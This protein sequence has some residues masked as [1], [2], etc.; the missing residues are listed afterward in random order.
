MRF[1]AYFDGCCLDSPRVQVD[2]FDSTPR[3]MRPMTRSA[4]ALGSAPKH[5]TSVEEVCKW[6]SSSKGVSEK[7]PTNLLKYQYLPMV[8]MTVRLKKREVK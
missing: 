4:V 3:L 6:I 5:V 2:L 7:R 8:V 1:F